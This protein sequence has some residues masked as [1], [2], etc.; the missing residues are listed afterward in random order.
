MLFKN[1]QIRQWICVISLVMCFVSFALTLAML[2]SGVIQDKGNSFQEKVAGNPAALMLAI[3]LPLSIGFH[4]LCLYKMTY[5]YTIKDYI[6]QTDKALASG[7]IPTELRH[8]VS[9]KSIDFAV[10]KALKQKQHELAI[11]KANKRIKNLD[12]KEENNEKNM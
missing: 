7:V 5:T 11:E 2:L 10:E 12:K 3:L 8:D 9:K 4:F 6:N 1:K